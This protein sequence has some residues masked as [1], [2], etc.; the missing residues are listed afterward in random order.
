MTNCGH[1]YNMSFTPADIKIFLPMDWV[2]KLTLYYDDV[3]NSFFV[4]ALLLDHN[5]RGSTLQIPNQGKTQEDRL[6]PALEAH[7]ELMKGTGHLLQSR[8]LMPRWHRTKL[9]GTVWIG[10]DCPGPSEHP[11]F[12]PTDLPCGICGMCHVLAYVILLYPR[13]GH[14]LAFICSNLSNPY[15]L[16]LEPRFCFISYV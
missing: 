9:S 14:N 8:T 10:P 4:H 6:R 5:A 1:I 16:F 2:P 3:W 13:F 12:C 7:N 11:S 15:V